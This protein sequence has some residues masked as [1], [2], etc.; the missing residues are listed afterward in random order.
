MY[1]A[2]QT[3]E[4]RSHDFFKY[5]SRKGHDFIAQCDHTYSSTN[6]S[7]DTSHIVCIGLKAW[8]LLDHNRIVELCDDSS[9]F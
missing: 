7:Y 4:S 3:T 9:R 6:E 1:F 5:L 2:G 8:F